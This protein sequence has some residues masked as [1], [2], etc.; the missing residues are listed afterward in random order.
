MALTTNSVGI[1]QT[2]SQLVIDFGLFETAVECDFD[3]FNRLPVYTPP[4]PP[5]AMA[6]LFT[7]WAPQ[8]SW[9]RLW[10]AVT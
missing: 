3:A 4:P 1:L 5:L 10:P 8:T 9:F 7:G 2:A 6:F